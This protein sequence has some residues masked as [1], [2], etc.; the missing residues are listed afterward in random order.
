L[1]QYINVAILLVTLYYP[2]NWSTYSWLLEG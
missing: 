1:A 2:G